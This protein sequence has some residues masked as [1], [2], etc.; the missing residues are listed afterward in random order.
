MK[1][2]LT[3]LQYLCDQSS[4]NIFCKRT[5]STN[6]CLHLR[7]TFDN[8]TFIFKVFS[9][10]VAVIPATLTEPSFMTINIGSDLTRPLP[11]GLSLNGV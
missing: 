11:D 6:K 9:G 3:T 4:Y 2:L 8:G 5:I 10:S 1:Y 7:T